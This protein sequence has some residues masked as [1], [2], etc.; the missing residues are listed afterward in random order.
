[1]K[2][3]IVYAR[4]PQ[5]GDTYMKAFETDIDAQIKAGFAVGLDPSPEAEHLILRSYSIREE[6]K[7]PQD[8]RFI[9]NWQANA[10]C[11]FMDLYYPLISDLTIPTFFVDKLEETVISK[12]K[13][14][15]WEKAFIKGRVHALDN[16]EAGL[17]V[18]PNYSISEI[19]DNYKKYHYDEP[20]FAVRQFYDPE[21]LFYYERYWV[22]NG[23]VFIKSGI[24][25]DIV[26]EAAE[27]LKAT[28]SKYFTID[29]TDE[30][31]ME[32]N[33]GESSDR[34]GENPPELFAEWFKQAFLDD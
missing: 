16:I 2:Y 23:K 20:P 7:Y 11:L 18:W 25:P 29:A 31:I 6:C 27:R 12:I 19:S 24:I 26:K 13:D 22:M 21:K 28:G 4:E 10:N 32:V 14:L 5:M 30:V 3:Q 34:F 8:S 17:C 33:P 15:G 9:N 1:M